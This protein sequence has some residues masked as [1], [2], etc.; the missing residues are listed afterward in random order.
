[1]TRF[2]FFLILIFIFLGCKK[3][4]SKTSITISSISDITATGVTI[5]GDLVID[6]SVSVIS[7]GICWSKLPKPVYADAKISI[8]KEPGRF[9]GVIKGLDVSTKYYVRAYVVTNLATIY[10]NELS[11]T[12]EEKF[13][14]IVDIRDGKS[15]RIVEIGSQTWF[16]E[17]LRY[18]GSIPEIKDYNLWSDTSQPAWCYLFNNPSNDSVYGKLYNW[19]AVEEGNVCPSGWHVPSDAEWTILTN[20]LDGS[21]VAGSKMKSTDGWGGDNFSGN[22]ESG[23]SA[24]PGGGRDYF[25]SFYYKN[26]FW[27]SST[28]S[29]GGY[30]AWYRSIYNQEIIVNRFYGMKNSGFSVRC[31]KD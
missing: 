27:W 26:G 7:T 30:S 12:T 11:F 13:K 19:Y 22:N 5:V 1:M 6:N 31:I 3:S 28:E 2:I 8:G 15:Y 16:A 24:L 14:K 25:S 10:G 29:D 20:Y 4:D 18:G 23:F 17:N 21:N 9:T